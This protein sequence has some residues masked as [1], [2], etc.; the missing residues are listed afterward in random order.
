M[1]EITV[2][3]LKGSRKIT[4]VFFSFETDEFCIDRTFDEA[5]SDQENCD[6]ALTALVESMHKSTVIPALRLLKTSDVPQP[7][8]EDIKT[9]HVFINLGVL[10]FIKIINVVVYNLQDGAKK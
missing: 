2:K 7:S 9:D 5:K 4:R 10:P 8:G 6:I 3:D 1:A